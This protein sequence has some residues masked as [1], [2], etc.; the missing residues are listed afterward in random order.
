[1]C[2]CRKGCNSKAQLEKSAGVLPR[3]EINR[4][5]NALRFN[6]R[7]HKPTGFQPELKD[8][9]CEGHGP[10]KTTTAHT[11][12]RAQPI[13]HLLRKILSLAPPLRDV[14]IILDTTLSELQPHFPRDRRQHR[15]L[16]FGHVK[17][18]THV[19]TFTTTMLSTSMITTAAALSYSFFFVSATRS[20]R[21]LHPHPPPRRGTAA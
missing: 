10:L 11:R 5:T 4:S 1:M 12:T 2:S 21:F 17:P 13:A 9:R 14:I 3:R 6:A 15:L 20:S 19:F 8:T 7:G 18:C 16:V